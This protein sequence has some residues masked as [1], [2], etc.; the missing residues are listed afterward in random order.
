MSKKNKKKLRK[1][2][3][4]QMMQQQQQ[5][6]QQ[7]APQIQ[8]AVSDSAV[9]EPTGQTITTPSPSPKVEIEGA[10]EVRHEIK[11]IL[12][13]MLLLFLLILGIYFI[14]TK[15]DITL[16]TGQFLLEKLHLNL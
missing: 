5:Q 16:K 10:V 4:H 3:R 8:T 13:T 12:L 9:S 2:L 1:A 7:A 11:K 14:N 15:T 6:Q